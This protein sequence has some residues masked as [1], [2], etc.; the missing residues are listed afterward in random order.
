MGKSYFNHERQT[1]IV[2]EPVCY[3]AVTGPDIAELI[4][5]T[6]KN[7]IMPALQGKGTVVRR[8]YAD[9]FSAEDAGKI[10]RWVEKKEEARANAQV[11]RR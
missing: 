7:G 4:D 1:S 10:S 11:K 2:I 5:W 8:T 6:V 3:V 9:F